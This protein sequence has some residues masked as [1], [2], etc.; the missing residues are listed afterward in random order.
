MADFKTKLKTSYMTGVRF[1]G[2]LLATSSG[3]FFLN[4]GLAI[5]ALQSL[6]T[7]SVASALLNKPANGQPL[8]HFDLKPGLFE[9]RSKHDCRWNWQCC[10]C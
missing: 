1:T 7:T 5:A 2:R 10:D 9:A 6:S 3:A 8:K 4:I